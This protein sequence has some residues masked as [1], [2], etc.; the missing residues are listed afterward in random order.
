MLPDHRG[1]PGAVAIAQAQ[2]RNG[3]ALTHGQ[4]LLG[5]DRYITMEIIQAADC[6][7]DR[8]IHGGS[9]RTVRRKLLAACKLGKTH[10]A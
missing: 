4:R 9:T 3:A 10:D 7:E 1:V 5:L 6:S 2:P 8:L